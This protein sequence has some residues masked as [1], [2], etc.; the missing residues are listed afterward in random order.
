[1]SRWTDQ[2]FLRDVQY[3]TPAT[4]ARLHDRRHAGGV[5]RSALTPMDERVTLDRGEE[6][7]RP[8]FGSVTRYD[9]VGTIVLPDLEPVVAYVRSLSLADP[10]VLVPAVMEAIR[11]PFHITTHSGCLVCR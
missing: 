11:V 10:D 6:L 8:V 5:P 2:A 1:M 4:A 7:V 9:F 3:R